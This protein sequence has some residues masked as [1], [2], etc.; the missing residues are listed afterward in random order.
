MNVIGVISEP[1]T[2]NGRKSIVIVHVICD[3]NE[4]LASHHHSPLFL[5]SVC[6]IA[7]ND[8]RTCVGNDQQTREWSRNM[9]QNGRAFAR[10]I[11]HE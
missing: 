8:L 2:V 9:G 3:W 6:L 11:R 1:F 7:F 5:G 10:T 4:P